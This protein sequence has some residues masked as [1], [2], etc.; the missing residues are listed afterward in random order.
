MNNA[1]S[2][3]KTEDYTTGSTPPRPEAGNAAARLQCSSQLV[4]QSFPLQSG[5]LVDRSFYGNTDSQGQSN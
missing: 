1:V 4:I 5:N 2:I 3:D